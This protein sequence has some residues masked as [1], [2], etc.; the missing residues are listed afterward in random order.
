M[1]IYLG[2]H[3]TETPHKTALVFQNQAYTYKWLQ[4]QTGLTAEF[5]KSQHIQTLAFC[6]FNSPVNVL[7]YLGAWQAGIHAF[8]INPRYID[9]ELAKLLTEFAPDAIVI[10]FSRATDLLIS[11]CK[12]YKITLITVNDDN[13]MQGDFWQKISTSK[14]TIQKER[15]NPTESYTYHLTSG[16]MG[17]S[18]AAIH[19]L[20]QITEYAKNR[21]VDMSFNAD[22]VLL[23]SLSL[24][25]AF[26]FS[27]QLLPGLALGL[28]M[29]LQ[30][31]F[32]EVETFNIIV[33]NPITS[34]ALL[35][36]MTYMLALY[37]EKQSKFT[38]VMRLPLVAGD[39][40][41]AAFMTKFTKVFHVTLYQGIGMTEVFGYAQNTPT[42]LNSQSTGRLFDS[43]KV[44][45]RNEHNEII[46]AGEIGNIF[47]QNEA[48]PRAYL[49]QPELSQKDLANGWV[50]T[51]D[52]G[53]IDEN[54]NFFFLGRK[55][56][57]II[58]SGSN[59]SSIEV[60]NALY[61]HKSIIQAAVVGKNDPIFGQVVWAYVVL[62]NKGSMD[63]KNVIQH[64]THYLS[65]YKIPEKVHFVETLPLNA[66]GKVDRFQLQDIANKTAT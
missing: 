28:T 57:I 16:A 13:P 60:E 65:T 23:I 36:S 56:Q 59:I 40:L 25:H 34:I 31:K 27:Y 21:A 26:S 4:K 11:T 7:C 20:A 47:L 3:A 44:E 17:H 62:D 29:H 14:A 53:Y 10:E 49:Q 8:P 30:P 37:A 51:G 12:Q 46:S 6:T 39:A 22:D 19:S 55:K 64:C 9:Y 33:N 41:P 58:H 43:V 54:R 5:L 63:E 48:T 52:I 32:S 18:K 66:T 45:I 61:Q 50:N 35:P 24:N 2:K 15:I 42:H 1:Q 38:H